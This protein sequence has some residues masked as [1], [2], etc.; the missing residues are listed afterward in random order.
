MCE[1][2]KLTIELVPAT[3][4][5]DN[6]R[7]R[8]APAEWDKIRKKAYADYDHKCGICG[9]E[10]RLNCHELWQYDDERHI[11]RLAGFIALCDLCHHIKHFGLA[12]ILAEEGKLDIEKVIEH[13]VKVNNCGRAE[14]EAHR[15]KA[16]EQWHERSQHQWH[17]DLGEYSNMVK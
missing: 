1:D 11:Q 17:I 2:M 12:G 16:F 14:F 13:F 4:W 6:L 9:S 7:K 5:Y 10:G 15:R 8:I 3:T